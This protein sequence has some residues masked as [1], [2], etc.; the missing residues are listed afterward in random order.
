MI[1]NLFLKNLK[2]KNSRLHKL[3]LSGLP[4]SNKLQTKLIY[5]F[6]NDVNYVTKRDGKSGTMDEDWSSD[7]DSDD[8]QTRKFFGYMAF[9]G[10]S[11]SSSSSGSDET[12]NDD[13]VD[14]E[15]DDQECAKRDLSDSTEC[16]DETASR[17]SSS[18]S[19]S[20]F[21]SP[22][23]IA[24]SSS[25]ASSNHCHRLTSCL[26]LKKRKLSRTAKAKREKR[27]KYAEKRATYVHQLNVRF[28]LGELNGYVLYKFLKSVYDLNAKPQLERHLA[29]ALNVNRLNL[30]VKGKHDFLI[31]KNFD[32]YAK[33]YLI[34][35]NN[36]KTNFSKSLKVIFISY[37]ETPELFKKYSP[38]K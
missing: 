34:V 36:V 8:Q 35:F 14:E 9:G 5:R 23:S 24:S 18:A 20:S 25:D 6:A 22:S 21:S 4:V 37:I 12:D 32:Q 30:T 26:R 7:S 11:S 38:K 1:T 16:L 28:D 15:N 33:V 13:E 17:W 27:I 31:S 29:L 10:S 2:R 3:D 19:S